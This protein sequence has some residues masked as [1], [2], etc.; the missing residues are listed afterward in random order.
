M[1][2]RACV[3]GCIFLRPCI[4]VCWFVCLFICGML[5]WACACARARVYMRLRVYKNISRMKVNGCMFE[6]YCV[7]T[8]ARV[9][10]REYYCASTMTRVL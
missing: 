2:V 1:R 9:L 3:H 7:S 10:L 4:F 8:I 5:A 6:Y